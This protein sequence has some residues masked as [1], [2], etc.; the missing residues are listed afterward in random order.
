MFCGFCEIFFIFVKI[1]NFYI[2]MRKN[3]NY[4]NFK[5]EFILFFIYL[6]YVNF[7]Y[8]YIYIYNQYFET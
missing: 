3:K 5:E 4:A 2:Q 1:C 7:I 6:L 8:I